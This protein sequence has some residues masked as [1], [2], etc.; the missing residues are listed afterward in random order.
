MKKIG[1]RKTEMGL[2]E[3]FIGIDGDILQ[4]HN[5]VSQNTSNYTMM[6]IFVE[7]KELLA[8]S[9]QIIPSNYIYIYQIPDGYKNFEELMGVFYSQHCSQ[10][11]SFQQW[12]VP[13]GINRDKNKN[14]EL[15]N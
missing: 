1:E 11:C 2:Y 12:S 14:F 4:K 5:I 9:N 3:F 6:V 8:K 7:K 15:W 13:A 10:F